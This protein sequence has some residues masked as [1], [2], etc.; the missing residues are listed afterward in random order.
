MKTAEELSKHIRGSFFGPN[1]T[2]SNVRDQ[3]SDV[4]REMA[5]EKVG[6]LN[7]IAVLTYH[8]F[9]FVN[10]QLHVLEGGPLEGSDKLSFNVPEFKTEEEWQKFVADSL[11]AANRHADLVAQREDSFLAEVCADEKYGTWFRNLEFLYITFTFYKVLM[12]R[13]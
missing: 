10:V 9:Y 6:D 8:I 11:D 4:T 2:F 3:L 13:T 1:W 12:L 7:T 5:F